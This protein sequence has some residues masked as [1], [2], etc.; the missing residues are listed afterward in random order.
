[1]KIAVAGKG[2]VGKTTL[3]AGLAKLFAARG[4][5][6][7]AVDAD[8]DVSLGATLGVPQEILEK[9]P[10]LME[11]KQ[12]IAERTGAGGLV[13]ILNPQVDDILEK[14]AIILG[15][16]RLLRMGAVKQAGTSC[17]CPEN[18]F[19]NAVLNSLLL[20]NREVVILDLGAGIEHL[21]RGTARGV[22]LM[23]VVTEPTR[24]SV[25][26]ARA[27]LK[28]ARELG[29][30]KLRVVGNKVRGSREREFL[31]ASFPG[32]ELAGCLEF[33]EGLWEKAVT[34][35]AAGFEGFLLETVGKVFDAVVGEVGE[36]GAARK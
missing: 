12:L 6:V 31:E 19:L 16:I 15:R 27:I 11:M 25:E 17:Y 29:I 33:S 28:L 36:T 30:P 21:T 34:G 20:G 23:L 18:A 4:Y 10:P 9:Q 14:Y 3:A 35:D 22:D 7:Y 26:T 24:V 32:G 8:P 2:G 5:E 13:Y 1:M